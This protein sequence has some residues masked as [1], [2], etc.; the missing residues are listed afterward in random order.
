MTHLGL[1][2]IAAVH[3]VF[4]TIIGGK[5]TIERGVSTAELLR[6]ATQV[7]SDTI[8]TNLL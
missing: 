6:I 3:A 4:D 2:E 8:Q 7:P 5:R 1:F